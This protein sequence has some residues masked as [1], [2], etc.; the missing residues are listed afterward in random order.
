MGSIAS[1]SLQ[2]VREDEEE[3][4]FS[5]SPS[6]TPGPTMHNGDNLQAEIED[7]EYH[8][9]EQLRNQLEHEDYNP[10]S[11]VTKP[12]APVHSRNQSSQGLTVAERFAN[13]PGKPM[14]LHHPRPHSRGHSLTQTFF[15]EQVDEHGLGKLGS[16]KELPETHKD[17]DEAQEIETNPSNLGTPV[18]DFDFAAAFGQHQKTFSTVSNPW[19]DHESGA[20]S[21]RRSSHGSKLSL[22]KLNVQAPEFKF[23]P[24]S[25]FTSGG[26]YNFSGGFQPAIFQAGVS[27]NAIPQ[28]L[29]PT[30]PVPQF[31]ASKMHASA[32]SFSPGQGVFSFSTSGP[33][34]RPDA[35]SFTPFQPLAITPAGGRGHTARQDSIFGNITI[36]TEDIVRPAKKSKAIPIIRPSSRSSAQSPRAEEDD[37]FRDGP[38]GRLADESRVKRAKSAAPDGDMLPAFAERPDE[39]EED[40]Q[41]GHAD[42]VKDDRSVA[43]EGSVDGELT[44]PGDTSLSSIVTSDQVDTKATTAAP[45]VTSPAEETIKSLSHPNFNPELATRELPPSGLFENKTKDS[46]DR[47]FLSANA[48]PFIP[49]ASPAA[50]L[51]SSDSSDKKED[52]APEEPAEEEATAEST[53][54]PPR[55][56]LT[57][58]PR[59][60]AASR[61]AKPQS[62]N[63]VEQPDVL[64]S[65]ET[66]PVTLSM[67]E[68]VTVPNAFQSRP[69]VDISE[70]REPTFEEIDAVMQQMETDPSMGVNK[71]L[72]SSNWQSHP[73]NAQ[74]VVLLK[75]FGHRSMNFPERGPV[76]LLVSSILSPMLLP[77]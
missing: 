59:G 6:K 51:A 21:T 70:D 4:D 67:P 55:A 46:E 18:Q 41:P 36:P 72:E 62:P 38:D 3:E 66:E 73:T 29:E 47:E 22:S 61:F 24:A 75:F 45:S 56:K 60:L 58:K 10:Q 26:M 32:P 44:Q 30:K 15:Q 53:P 34:F 17:E 9:E 49:V 74:N 8:L 43:E 40:I 76:L 27:S 64:Q 31:G 33:K 28:S 57:P 77:C 68:P 63:L 20:S 25:T 52:S 71:L 19:Q 16:L 12:F 11:V 13:E 23:N 14:E 48:V 7:A 50:Q 54:Q 35:P 1:P 65:I 69:L 37:K 42:E 39:E 2:D 5:K